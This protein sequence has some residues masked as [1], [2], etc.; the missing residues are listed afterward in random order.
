MSEK[1]RFPWPKIPNFFDL[2]V[3]K[4]AT[5]SFH[6]DCNSF[7][8]EK[9]HGLNVCVSSRGYIGSRR[10]VVAK[11]GDDL[12]N[13][14]ITCISLENLESLFDKVEE[15]NKEV[16]LRTDLNE[17]KLETLVYGEMLTTGTA[18]SKYDIYNYRERGLEAGHL[19]VFGMG[20]VFHKDDKD[21]SESYSYLQKMMNEFDSV[22]YEYGKIPYC[23][24][25]MN[26]VLLSLLVQFN[27]ETVPFI[28][29]GNFG[30]FLEDKSS[31]FNDVI[32][33][34][35]EGLV[36]RT[37]S[38]LM[39]LK[40]P[41]LNADYEKS[42][43]V[44]WRE[45]NACNCGAVSRLKELVESV[46]LFCPLLE[47]ERK[48]FEEKFKLVYNSKKFILLTDL[49]ASNKEPWKFDTTAFRKI[50]T[51]EIIESIK[52]SYYYEEVDPN[53]VKDIEQKLKQ[54]ML[55]VMHKIGRNWKTGTDVTGIRDEE[56]ES[57]CCIL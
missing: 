37:D 13:K 3:S 54:K 17:K 51:A 25:P 14:K 23:T 34:K 33:R 22:V 21:D 15:L 30:K 26:T 1:L 36:I 7:V 53:L 4:D 50:L 44:V 46:Y 31:K 45:K 32:E 16:A 19:Y 41:E 49:S 6:G 40:Y 56:L 28:F 42:T 12:F 5:E 55:K 11:K 2:K 47:L 35:I 38:N 10:N 29:K 20:T 18:R 43:V 57:H 24:V 27:F 8:T 9:L 48:I 52:K 39:K